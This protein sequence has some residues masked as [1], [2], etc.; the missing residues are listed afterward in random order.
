MTL[1]Q[2]WATTYLRSVTTPVSGSTWRRTTWTALAHVTVG[3][4]WQAVASK[5]GAATPAR[6]KVG[7]D[8]WMTWASATA[9]PGAPR[10]DTRLS[11]I[12]RSSGAASRSRAAARTSF[13][14]TAVAA[15]WTEL[16]AFT[17]LRLAKVPTPKATAAVSPPTTVTQSTGTPSASAAT[18][19][20]VVSWP[21][22][23]EALLRAPELGVARGG[24]RRLER[25]T[26][27]AAV[28]DE[29]VAVAVGHPEVPRKLVRAQVVP[30]ADLRRVQADPPREAVDGPVHREDG[31]RPT[32][33]AVRG[34]GG[35]VGDDR[36][37]LHL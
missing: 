31:L 18:W 12:V 17:A 29:R 8:A 22:P 35:L 26:E 16:P 34:A 14:R 32:R 4:W 28:G 7:S 3:T 13:A 9:E 6:A 15:S 20:N 27:I 24:Q 37:D 33:P 10:T 30:A 21:W 1:P 36:L 25:G 19:A 5:S 11:S 23:A 2:S